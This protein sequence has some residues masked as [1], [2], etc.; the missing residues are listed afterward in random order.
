M[1]CA[2]ITVYRQLQLRLWARFEF[3]GK[4][5]PAATATSVKS[6]EGPFQ[7]EGAFFVGWNRLT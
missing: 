5:H 6:Q 4:S 3:A 7:L 2:G 1:V